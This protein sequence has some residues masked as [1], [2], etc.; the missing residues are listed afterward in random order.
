MTRLRRQEGFTLPE[1]LIGISMS[2]I[3]ALA[4]FSLLETAMRRTGQTQ[5]RVEATQRGRQALDT[6]TRQL[7]SQVCLPADQ[8]PTGTVIAQPAIASASPTS[9]TFFSDLSTGSGTFANRV[10]KRV[11]TYD[12]SKKRIVEERYKTTGVTPLVFK[13]APES[14]KVLVT[15]VVPDPGNSVF[16]YYAF[17]VA[18]A[19]EIPKTNIE[20]T[21]P[22]TTDIGRIARVD[23]AFVTRAGSEVATTTN[24]ASLTLRTQVYMRAADPNDPAPYPTC[25]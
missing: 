6:M 25:V 5:D 11:L 8:L 9:V 23:I 15:N 17:G 3:I 12:A 4:C 20:L 13:A 2:M 7:R 1:L 18:T 24:D 21:N 10:E 14:R 16:R 19:T 22:G